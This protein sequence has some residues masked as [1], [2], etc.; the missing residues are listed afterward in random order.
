MKVRAAIGI[1]LALGAVGFFCA[2]GFVL[3]SA[4]NASARAERQ[5]ASTN[6]QCLD[7]LNTIA[8]ASVA[9]MGDD[10][11]LVI[12]DVNDPK[13]ALSDATLAIMMCPTKKVDSVCLGDKCQ[14]AQDKVI[15]RV[16]MV[17]K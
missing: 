12:R 3:A 4:M 15:L 14:G 8:T 11:T 7:F 5:I 1:G 16:K 6:K 13:T 10:I 17:S 9:P 2:G